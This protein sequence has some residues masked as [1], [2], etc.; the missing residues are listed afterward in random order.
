MENNAETLSPHGNG[1]NIASA[2]IVVFDRSSDCSGVRSSLDLA[3]S[4]E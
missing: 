4:A 3:L 1:G 2:V